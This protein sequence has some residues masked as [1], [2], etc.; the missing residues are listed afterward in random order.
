[1]TKRCSFCEYQSDD[2]TA[3]AEHMRTVHKWDQL[4]SPSGPKA[5]TPSAV[6]FVIGAGLALAFNFALAVYTFEGRPGLLG[7]VIAWLVTIGGFALLYRLHHWAAFGAL[8]I[9]AALFFVLLIAGGATGP[10]T[11]FNAYGYPSAR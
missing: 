9:Y 6:A 4:G 11:C 10:Y 8:G 5:G 1:M 2:E 7:I 3:F